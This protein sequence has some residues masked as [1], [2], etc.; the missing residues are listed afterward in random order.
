M[1]VTVLQGLRELFLEGCA[2]LKDL[3]SEATMTSWILCFFIAPSKNQKRSFFAEVIHLIMN[4]D[5]LVSLGGGAQI[6]S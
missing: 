5:S 4:F 6:L 3:I 2:F 1:P